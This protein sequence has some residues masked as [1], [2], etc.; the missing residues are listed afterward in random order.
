MKKQQKK[1]WIINYCKNNNIEDLLNEKYT[2]TNKNRHRLDIL[3]K[4]SPVIQSI[5]AIIS[6][7]VVAVTS[8]YVGS[9]ANLISAKQ[10]E[11]LR[12]ENKPIITFNLVKGEDGKDTIDVYSEATSPKSYSIEVATY[13]NIECDENQ[14]NGEP[15][16]VYT[17]TNIK[18][19][20]RKK[21]E[22]GKISEV[23]VYSSNYSINKI[24]NNELFYLARNVSDTT[25]CWRATHYYL[26]KVIC[27]DIFDEES[28]YY[29]LYDGSRGTEISVAQ[30]NQLFL[31]WKQEIEAWQSGEKSII[32]SN[33][34]RFENFEAESILYKGVAELRR[35]ELYAVDSNKRITYGEYEPGYYD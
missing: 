24:I 12:L 35:K 22:S 10:L 32:D 3:N 4:Y 1:E 33:I 6:I 13:Y 28:V 8:W 9:Q 26:V 23:F 34:I 15:V 7:I 27:N 2:K 16:Y 11:I 30:G 5:C 17:T 31:G 29:Y 25:C 14:E 19:T 20:D 21:D 18:K